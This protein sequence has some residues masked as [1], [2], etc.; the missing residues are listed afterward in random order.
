MYSR[1]RLNLAG[2]QIKAHA[3]EVDGDSDEDEDNGDEALFKPIR[4]K[5]AA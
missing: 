4:P 3:E 1:L 2:N 5:K